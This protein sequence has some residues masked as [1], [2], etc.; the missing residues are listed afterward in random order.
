MCDTARMT[1]GRFV[2]RAKQDEIR[3]EGYPYKQHTLVQRRI[4]GVDFGLRPK[5]QPRPQSC[6]DMS[7]RA[8]TSQLSGSRQNTALGGESRRKTLSAHPMVVSPPRSPRELEQMS[9]WTERPDLATLSH[10]T[11]HDCPGDECWE[12]QDSFSSRRGRIPEW[13]FAR[14]QGRQDL[15]A[16]TLFEPGKYRIP[17][18]ALDQK[19]KVGLEFGQ[20]LSRSTAASVM[21]HCT[22]PAGLQE[23]RPDR[24]DGRILPD[25]SLHRGTTHVAPRIKS[26]ADF[27]KGMARPELAVK[28]YSLQEDSSVQRELAYNAAI[29]DKKT[30][31]RRDVGPNLKR[32]LP[33]EKATW[34]MRNT[35]NDVAMCL[36]AQARLGLSFP[37]TISQRKHPV[38]RYKEAPSRR[39]PDIGRSFDQVRARQHTKVFAKMS[40]LHKSREQLCPTFERKAASGFE[41]RV[42]VGSRDGSRRRRYDALPDWQ[43]ALESAEVCDAAAAVA[44]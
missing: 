14:R 30:S 27:Q 17:W 11:F 19:S 16:A 43:S 26:V 4:A 41:P 13:D 29:A 5:T 37:A 32:C 28:D 21:G 38:E 6:S 35:H 23:N 15:M 12:E 31:V 36:L 42:D 20:V 44:A 7:T 34:G 39:R 24:R 2:L 8:S 3:P 33:V 10:I 9:L 40:P 22:V 25:R 18:E 1:M